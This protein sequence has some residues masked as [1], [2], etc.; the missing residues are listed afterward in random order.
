[1]EGKLMSVFKI[2]TT[3]DNANKFST[4]DA[5]INEGASSLNNTVRKVYQEQVIILHIIEE[6]RII[7]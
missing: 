1:V 4:S 3:K 6:E 2:E 5:F 7:F